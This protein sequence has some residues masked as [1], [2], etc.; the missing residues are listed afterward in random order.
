MLLIPEAL[1]RARSRTRISGSSHTNLNISLP[2][3]S[4]NLDTPQ[5]ICR[6]RRAS[7]SP[8]SSVSVNELE[9][10][11]KLGQVPFPS[12]SRRASWNPS[13]STAF[14]L[15]D[16]TE[17][18]FQPVPVPSEIIIRPP[19]S[20]SQFFLKQETQNRRLSFQLEAEAQASRNSGLPIEHPPR[21]PPRRPSAL[22]RPSLLVDSLP[23]RRNSETM[24]ASL[25]PHITLHNDWSRANSMV[26]INMERSRNGSLM[27]FESGMPG[28]YSRNA[29]FIVP[30]ELLQKGWAHQEVQD[31]F[32]P[33]YSQELQTSAFRNH[34]FSFNNNVEI[35]ENWEIPRSFKPQQAIYKGLA[36]I[37][38]KKPVRLSSF[39]CVRSPDLYSATC[40]LCTWK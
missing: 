33:D 20:E 39:S 14:K 6:S 16:A 27:M 21:S 4:S 22:I 23:S 8:S 1:T 10:A 11:N 2:V 25:D 17:E 29:S 40:P 9:V 38:I 35:N 18:E 37:E 26:G 3:P 7:F 19:T 31:P 24:D 5:D 34:D 36:G 13:L 30:E 32:N 12:R 15:D 28:L